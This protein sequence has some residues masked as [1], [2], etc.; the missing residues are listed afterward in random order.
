MVDGLIEEG[1]NLAGSEAERHGGE[2][3]VF[4]DV[5]GVEVDVAVSPLAVLEFGALEDS[6]PEKNDRSCCAEVLAESG[7]GEFA[8]EVVEMKLLE[9][10]VFDVIMVEAVVEVSDIVDDDVGFD[11]VEGAGGGG[12]SEFIAGLGSLDA[13]GC[14]EQV[15]K[16]IQF[17]RFV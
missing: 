16:L 2:G 10:M 17:K 1:A 4:G 14:P 6:A 8:A 12:G 9:P 15:G 5:A 7:R 13:R 11:G 3:E